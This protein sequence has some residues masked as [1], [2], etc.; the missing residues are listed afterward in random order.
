MSEAEGMGCFFLLQLVLL[1]C[2]CVY[3]WN[4]NATWR[5]SHKDAAAVAQ[6]SKWR[7]AF[8]QKRGRAPTHDDC[9]AGNHTVSL[10][11]PSSNDFQHISIWWLLRPFLLIRM[12]MPIADSTMVLQP[13]CFRC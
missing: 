5:L 10:L 13:G 8:E 2:M 9:A 7:K 12:L 1:R 6:L 3:Q 11:Y 4:V